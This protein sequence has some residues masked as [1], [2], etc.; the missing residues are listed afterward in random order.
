MASEQFTVKQGESPSSVM[1]GAGLLAARVVEGTPPGLVDLGRKLPSG[2]KVEPVRFSDPEGRELLWHSASHLMAQA[3]KELYPKAFLTIGPAVDDG[4]Y[5]DIDSPEAITV[6]DLPR[7]EEKMREIVKRDLPV[8]REEMTREKAVEF[9]KARGDAYKVEILNEIPEGTVSLYRQGDFVDLCRGPH[10]PSTGAIG[11]FKLMSI[12]GAYWR[13]DEKNKMLTRLYGVA[14]PSQAELDEWL[15]LVEEAKKRDHRVLG[16]ELDLFSFHEE[17]GPGL[18]YWHPKGAVV[19]RVIED[20]WRDEHVKNGYELLFSPHIGKATLW[21][22]SGHL[23]F[24]KE[25][26]YAPIE[27]EGQKY[28][29]KPMNCPFHVLIFK[30]RQWSYRE[31]PARYCE[32]GTVYRYERSGTLQGLLR[33]RGFT[34]DD[35]HIFMRPDQLGE[36]LKGVVKF[37]IFML[38]SFGFTDFE[39]YLS[40]RPEQFIGEIATWDVAEA[41]LADA[42]KAS[43]LEYKVDP[44]AGVFYGPK[45]DIKVKDALGRAWQCSTVQVDFNMPERFDV[46]YTGEDGAK[47]RVVM[48]HR[49]LLGSMERFF[50]AMIEHYRGEFPLWL[51]PV[52]AKILTITSNEEAYAREVLAKL[53]AAGIRAEADWGAEKI[54][55]KI[56]KAEIEKVHFML[57]MGKREAADGKVSVRVKGKGDEGAVPV[58]GFIRRAVEE[59]GKKGTQ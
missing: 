3:V 42:L 28:Y 54:G 39:S 32:L 16:R 50:G 4:F 35:A 38:R 5:Y 52:Q 56:R 15:K 45:I 40:T 25:S 17:G 55:Y 12:A 34:Q 22:T 2:G 13:G 57:V 37:V 20:F 31:L 30:N 24:Y 51:A 9:F 27:I 53:K 14:F 43:G 48:I 59:A 33:V 58:D 6:A 46:T 11:A 7:I 1:S 26:M 47:K 21:E 10:V 41:A 49:A 18:A 19:R 8:T 44:G 23:G 29:L 36:E